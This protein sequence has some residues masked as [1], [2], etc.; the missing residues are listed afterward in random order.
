MSFLGFF[1]NPQ[2]FVAQGGFFRCGWVRN[3]MV[4]DGG[5]DGL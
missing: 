2:E 5:N 3:M 1:S 4:D